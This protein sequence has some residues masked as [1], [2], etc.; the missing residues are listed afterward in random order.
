MKF[1]AYK[2]NS[3][4]F[5][6]SIFSNLILHAIVNGMFSGVKDHNSFWDKALQ[7]F[8]TVIKEDLENIGEYQI[9]NDIN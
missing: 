7:I 6:F 3:T 2:K 5:V 4:T 8:F 1:Y 9:I